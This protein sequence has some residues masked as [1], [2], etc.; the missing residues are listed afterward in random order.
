M[1]GEGTS[2]FLSTIGPRGYD[3]PDR[4]GFFATATQGTVKDY[5]KVSVFGSILEKLHLTF[6]K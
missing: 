6:R 5:S 4:C 2:I 1:A 3:L